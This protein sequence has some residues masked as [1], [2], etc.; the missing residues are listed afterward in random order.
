MVFNPSNMNTIRRI[1]S[2]IFIA[3]L[4]MNTASNAQSGTLDTTF[5]PGTGLE[6]SSDPKV[7]A[8]VLLEDGKIL[9]GGH[10]T[11]YNG[12]TFKNLGR[13]N[14][15]G[16]NDTSF[17]QYPLW[18]NNSYI[19]DIAL[20]PDGRFLVGG[21]FVNAGA[22]T[23]IGRFHAN[24]LPDTT[25][26]DKSDDFNIVNAIAIQAD[27]KI[28]IGG[29]FSRY[30]GKD[31]LNIARL[32]T[33]GSLDS[34]FNSSGGGAGIV[35]QTIEEVRSIVVQQDQKILIGGTFSKYKGDVHKYLLRLN[36]DGS[37]DESFNM[38]T[39][40]S[41][42]V[43]CLALYPDEKI[44]VGGD[45]IQYQ[46]LSRYRLARIQP[47][48][49]IDSSFNPA[50]FTPYASISGTNREVYNVLLQPDG[51]IIV[52]GNFSKYNNVIRKG[53]VRIN[54]DGSPDNTFTIGGG[55]QVGNGDDGDVYE[56]VLQ[57]DGK[58][59]VGGAFVKYNNIPRNNIVRLNGDV[60]SPT[61]LQL[62]TDNQLFQLYPNPAGDHVR[63]ITPLE[64]LNYQVSDISGKIVLAGQSGKN[65]TTIDLSTLANGI[66]F[67][68]G[69]ANDRLLSKKLIVSR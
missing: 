55:I 54:A 53:I 41:G 63:I 58:V 35:N 37:I 25:F 33:D 12:E 43:N 27:G 60:G 4:A 48:G 16:S 3:L 26:H 42:I 24:G 29:R 56:M 19:Y 64:K 23:A 11:T 1:Q 34:T 17:K 57:P 2:V 47:N 15:D 67:A 9:L 31:R 50:A 8:M 20:Q 49:V 21:Q 40:I 66:Y 65:N 46:G 39:G 45:F 68:L 69:N 7:N 14:E 32:N 44:F 59:V 13:V 61:G 22:L 38:G 52:G 36:E 28:L 18:L 10:S 62:H 6:G 51:K 5:D 30:A